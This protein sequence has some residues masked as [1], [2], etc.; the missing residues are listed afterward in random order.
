MLL[1]L[2]E[3]FLRV[4]GIQRVHGRTPHIHEQSTVPGLEYEL[5]PNLHAIRGFNWERIS[6][7]S[8][9]FRSP[10]LDSNKPTIA[11]LG[12]SVTFGFGVEDDQTN[13][14]PLRKA[15]PN[16]NVLN[17]GTN[18]YNIEQETHLFEAKVKKIDLKLVI[19][20]FVFNDVEPPT[21][22]TSATGADFAVRTDTGSTNMSFRDKLIHASALLSFLEIRTKGLF[23]R[24]APNQTAYVKE[25][26]TPDQ[27]AYYDTWLT[28]LATDIGGVPHIFVLWPENARLHREARQALTAMAQKNGFHVLDLTSV[29]GDRYAT[30]GW[31]P[32]PNPTVQ[33]KVGNVLAAFIRQLQLGQK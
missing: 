25:T 5:L 10:E 11:L 16:F 6:T 7:N 1:L 2:M 33:E 17:T 19:L 13:S 28:R 22:M 26:V 29:L 32:H 30:L 21:R 9:G 8:L 14:E 27:L 31:D 3:A 15:F 24:S 20:E 12:D 4:S 23:F 18:G